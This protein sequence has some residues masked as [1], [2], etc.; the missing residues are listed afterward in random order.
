MYD[1]ASEFLKSVLRLNQIGLARVT[2][3]SVEILS[4]NFFLTSRPQHMF[5]T[6]KPTPHIQP[7]RES[8]E[9]LSSLIHYHSIHPQSVT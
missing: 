3:P 7:A 2:I 4:G 6:P 1:F 8:L 9:L 5:Y